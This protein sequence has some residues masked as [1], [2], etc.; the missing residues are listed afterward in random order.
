M[1][2]DYIIEI[3][4]K[5]LHIEIEPQYIKNKGVAM[6]PTIDGFEKTAERL[7]EMFETELDIVLFKKEED[8]D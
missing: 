3:M 2:K 8:N 4:K 1:N 5:N 6:I 7:S